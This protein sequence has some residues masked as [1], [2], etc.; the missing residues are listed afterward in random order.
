MLMANANLLL[1]LTGVYVIIS[2][3]F[4]ILLTSDHVS[5]KTSVECCPSVAFSIIEALNVVYSS[6]RPQLNFCH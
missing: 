2:I 3:F 1:S 5:K 4:D 6:L